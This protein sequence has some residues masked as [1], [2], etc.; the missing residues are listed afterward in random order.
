MFPSLKK[1]SEKN[2]IDIMSIIPNFAE[3]KKKIMDHN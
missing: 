2:K 3:C 1:L